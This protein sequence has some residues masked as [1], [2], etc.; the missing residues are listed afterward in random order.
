M[1]QKSVQSA[2]DVIA[3]ALESSTN[4]C[5]TCSFQ[6][7]DVAILDLIRRQCP[8]VTI[9]FLETGYH[10]AS[11]IAYRDRLSSEWNLQLVN[12][13]AMQTV[14][15]QEAEFGKLY[16][17]DPNRCC[18]LRK[19]EPLKRGVANHDLWFT[20]LRREQSPTRANLQPFETHRFPDGRTL[21]KVSPLY[22]WTTADVFVYLTAND[23]PVVSLYSEGYTSIGCEP[24][25]A[26]PAVGEH[27]RSGRWGG[28]KLECGLHTESVKES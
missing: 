19:V 5:F 17:T 28:R 27:A 18:Y 7:E 16:E 11:L 24:C 13:E 9:L 22:D 20:G 26:K 14:A 1:L 8:D 12:M 4:P 10:F 23:I 21:A 2:R 25:T 15:V 6:A 3:K